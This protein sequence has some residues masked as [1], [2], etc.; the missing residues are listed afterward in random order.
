MST[1]TYSGFYN[2][3]GYSNTNFT[4][5]GSDIIK[6]F[7][8]MYNTTFVVSTTAASS[9]TSTTVSFD[10]SCNAPPGCMLITTY[11]DTSSNTSST[12]SSSSTYY[13]IAVWALDGSGNYT[14]KNSSITTGSLKYLLNYGNSYFYPSNFSLSSSTSNLT[15]SLTKSNSGTPGTYGV[16]VLVL[17]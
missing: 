6:S 11:L 16:S 10:V 5:T 3:Q 12:Y 4:Y 15:I 17:L 2:K 13:A 9:T 8:I 7:P 14:C 1:Y